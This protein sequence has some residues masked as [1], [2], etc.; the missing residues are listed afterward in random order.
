MVAAAAAVRR[1]VVAAA[2]RA[3]ATSVSYAPY[4]ASFLVVWFVA[5]VD[6]EGECFGEEKGG[7][8]AG[9]QRSVVCAGSL[10]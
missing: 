6:E 5:V 9:I 1:V 7:M 4:A 3:A 2:Y 8:S 10:I